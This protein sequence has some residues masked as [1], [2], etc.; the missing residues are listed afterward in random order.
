MVS[1]YIFE[2]SIVVQSKMVIHSDYF[3]EGEKVFRSNKNENL[4][5]DDIKDHVITTKIREVI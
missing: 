2:Y 1:N 4:V 5:Y 3:S